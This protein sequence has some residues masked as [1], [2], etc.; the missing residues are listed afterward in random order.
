MPARLGGEG[1]GHDGVKEGRVGGWG[2][3][4]SRRGDSNGTPG[5]DGLTRPSL[6][7]NIHSDEHGAPDD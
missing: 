7:P 1:G 3:S 2:C 6:T 5:W 4:N